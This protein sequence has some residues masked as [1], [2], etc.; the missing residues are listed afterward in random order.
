MT[1]KEEILK[2][3]YTGIISED[4][5]EEGAIT[6]EAF[7]TYLWKRCLKTQVKKH[8]GREYSLPNTVNLAIMASYASQNPSWIPTNGLYDFK[9]RVNEKVKMLAAQDGIKIDVSPA[10]I[11]RAVE[12]YRQADPANKGMNLFKRA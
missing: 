11:D 4:I 7:A 12:Q 1:I 3:T 10:V 2:N 9:K 8:V 5:I 6:P